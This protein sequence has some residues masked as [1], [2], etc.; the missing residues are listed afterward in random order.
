MLCRKVNIKYLCQLFGV[1]FSINPILMLLSVFSPFTFYSSIFC[2]ILPN[3]L[4]NQM[5]SIYDVS[6]ELLLTY[7]YY[8]S[9]ITIAL[10]TPY[11]YYIYPA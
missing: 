8:H 2:Y 3:L 6:N 9:I 10:L 1:P 4:D 5:E 11:Y 7:Y